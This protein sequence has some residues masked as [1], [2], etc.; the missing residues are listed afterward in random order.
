MLC[1][2]FVGYCSQAYIV[3]YKN[4]P[5]TLHIECIWKYPIWMNWIE[6]CAVAKLHYSPPFVVTR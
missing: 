1:V 2:L 3:L 6:M 4:K 5:S